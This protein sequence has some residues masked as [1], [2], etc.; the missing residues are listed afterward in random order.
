MTQTAIS[1]AIVTIA[2]AE[3][4]FGLSRTEDELFFP[5]WQTAL[6]ELQEVE[7]AELQV[8]RRRYLYHRTDDHLLEGAVTLLLASPLLTIA[9]F[10]DPPFR[11]KAE[12][13]VQL[14]LNDGE[15]ILQGRLDVLVVQNRLWVLVVESKKTAIS[16][17]S[18]LPQALAYLTASPNDSAP[19]FGMVT[20]GDEIL[21]VKMR[22]S[23]YALSRIF[24]PFISLGELEQVTRIL[25]G[26][27]QGILQSR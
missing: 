22:S 27:G 6:P 3:Q 9:G 4:R 10:Y 2:Q 8:M 7:R 5:E 25:R 1:K 24:A 16:A 14:S 17:L 15:E 11:M 20:N 19:S 13:S 21:L 12:T 18:G 23:Q 26:I